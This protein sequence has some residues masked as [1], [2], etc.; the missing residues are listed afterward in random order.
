M[1]ARSTRHGP[2]GVGFFREALATQGDGHARGLLEASQVKTSG[3]VTGL[4]PGA[5]PVAE[6]MC[7]TTTFFPGHEHDY[8]GQSGISAYKR[9]RENKR[10]QLGKIQFRYGHDKTDAVF[11]DCRA[12]EYTKLYWAV[13]SPP[14]TTSSTSGTT[15]LATA[16]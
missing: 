10:I 3:G 12:P 14:G 6:T 15:T 1:A 5:R 2:A 13:P 7:N 8:D 4:L 16:T 9:D 11:E